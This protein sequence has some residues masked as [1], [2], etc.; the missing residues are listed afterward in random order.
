M[1]GVQPAGLALLGFVP[2]AGISYIEGCLGMTEQVNQQADSASYSGEEEW[3]SWWDGARGTDMEKHW[4]EQR[5]CQARK[6]GCR[7]QTKK[8]VW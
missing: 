1:A 5:Q 2:E 6:R 7:A 4:K 3:R 8:R